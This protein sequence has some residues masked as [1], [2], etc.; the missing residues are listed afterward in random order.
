M[1]IVSFPHT[2]CLLADKFSFKSKP[3]ILKTAVEEV[4]IVERLFSSSLL[5]V[6][7]KASPRKLRVC[8]FLKGAEICTYSHASRILAVKMN[9]D[10]SKVCENDPPFK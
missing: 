6:V 9:R 5:A 1:K 8:H 2:A 3:Y 4:Y 10:V 7:A